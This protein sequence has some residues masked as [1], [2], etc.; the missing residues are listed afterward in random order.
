MGL[1][2]AQERPMRVIYDENNRPSH[3]ER[4]IIV[5]FDPAM[6]RFINIDNP[7]FQGGRLND[8]I[9]DSALESVSQ[10]L[11]YSPDNIEAFKI[12]THM[13]S[14]DTVS[15]NQL[16]DTIRLDSH[17]ASFVLQLPVGA[18]EQA[19]CDNLA[20][21]FPLVRFAHLNYVGEAT[22][23]QFTLRTRPNDAA[24]LPSQ[25][26]LHPT[27]QYPNGHINAQGAWYF[28]KGI[29]TV[30]AGVLDSGIDYR[31]VEFNNGVS[32]GPKVIG[33][34]D[35]VNNRAQAN[36][37]DVFGH[38]TAVA[39]IIG[40]RRNNGLGIAGIAGGNGTSATDVGAQLFDLRIWDDFGRGTVAN[41]AAAIVEGAAYNPSTGYGYGLHILNLSGRWY[42][43]FSGQ[44]TT[45]SGYDLALLGSAV[46]SAF[47]NN[48]TFVASKGNEGTTDKNYPADYR[49]GWVV[50]VGASGTNGQY[51]DNSNGVSTVAG[52]NYASNRGNGIDLIAPGTAGLVYT[53][54]SA[55]KSTGSGG[56][57]TFN[58]TSAAAPHVAGVAA[59]LMSQVNDSSI[60]N[61]N[62]APED[63]EQLLQR[64]ATDRGSAGYDDNTGFG[65]LNAGGAVAIC[66]KNIYKI[67]HART[68][69]AN[70]TQVQQNV[71]VVLSGA[72]GATAAGVYYADV[73]RGTA[74]LSNSGYVPSGYDIIDMWARNSSSTLW[75]GANPIIPEPDITVTHDQTT[76][77]IT[78]YTY[79]LRTDITGRRIN[80]WLPTAP[81]T[82]GPYTGTELAVTFY[83][84]N[85]NYI[86]QPFNR[87]AP[88]G[89]DVSGAYPNPTS[90]YFNVHYSTTKPVEQAVIEVYSVTGVQVQRLETTQLE[91]GQHNEQVTLKG[92]PNG[93]YTYRLVTTTGVEV[94]RIIKQ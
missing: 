88:E 38:G 12:F 15:I 30:K 78:G 94:G 72:A 91:K 11:G 25:A 67:S 27:Q 26:N 20:L 24:Y 58:G 93:L 31:H 61:D 8:F 23:D 64:S 43:R 5:R 6:V 68:I 33:G 57:Q 63:V 89:S 53:T 76:T 13:S 40:A 35:W 22:I 83:S 28:Q 3:I 37:T 2:R 14:A 19:A 86:E 4:E 79:Y 1:V 81:N 77:Y 62:L 59:L 56:Y 55:N 69:F 92:L 75:S 18:S 70:F 42:E 17:W 66:R 45:A 50:S 71:R 48:V 82:V 87:S 46:R 73:Y 16:G 41:A 52:D 51:K 21:L 9:N 29:N 39:G 60:P 85:P 54:R 47:T 74:Q 44:S 10:A 36:I 90:E 7:A 49:D 34:W 32:G 84:Y 80:Q 65:L